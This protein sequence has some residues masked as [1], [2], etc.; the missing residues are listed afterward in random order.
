MIKSND[1]ALLILRL[2]VG[3]LLLLHGIAKLRSGF[4]AGLQGIEGM[5]N[6]KGLPESLAIGVYVGEVLAPV[7]LL[8]GWLV[9]IAA[10]TVAFNM[11]LSI[12]LAYGSSAFKLNSHGGLEVE[13]NV[14]YLAGALA[15]FLAGGGRY[16][17]RRRKHDDE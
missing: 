14:L 7:M 2:A 6:E 10:G 5:L 15:L 17:L 16:V 4:D 12:W 8:G 3:G 9:R 1:L 11:I 13:L